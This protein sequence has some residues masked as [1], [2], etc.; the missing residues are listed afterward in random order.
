MSRRVFAD[1]HHSALY[2]SLHLL[3]EKRL[4]WE[5]YR[6]I[7]PEWYHAGFWKVFDHPATVNQFLGLHLASTLPCSST[8][9]LL[10]EDECRNLNHQ[11]KDGIYYIQET[12][13][14]CNYRAVTLDR[15]K[16]MEFD[17]IIS[18]I[19]QHIN[20]FNQLISQFQ[21]RAKHV[22]QVGNA[23]GHQPGVKNILA[24]TAPFSVP[25]GVNVCNYH[26]EFD[27]DVFTY[28]VPSTYN[29]VNSYIHYM[30]ELNLMDQ[31][32]SFLPEWKFQSFG[33][34]MRD[35]LSGFGLIAD[36]I[37]RSSFTWHYKPEGDGYGFSIH[38]SYA[39]GR[40]A[41]IV[42][43]HYAGKLA[44]FLF[45]DRITCLNIEGIFPSDCVKLIE[46]YGQPEEHVKMCQASYK[47]FTSIVNFDDQFETRIKPF[48]GRLL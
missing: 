48:L 30:K 21:P 44:S 20:P 15:F 27:L 34:G 33:A 9:N 6:P 31:V 12:E 8:E 37:R 41:I 16:E 11:E 28:E 45:E 3:F 13:T 17:I 40:P 23:W 43:S 35:S 24:S 46:H 14:G 19:P 32:A 38:N 36:A 39:C 18:S 4:G 42:R 2:H 22:F 29:T 7:G 25:A 47:R 1:F 26:Q 5:L 10:S